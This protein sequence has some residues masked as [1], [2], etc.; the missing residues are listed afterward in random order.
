MTPRKQA[1]HEVQQRA[2]QILDAAAQ[3]FASKGFHKATTRDIAA[4]AQ[5]AEGTLYNYYGSKREMLFALMQRLGNMS[6]LETVQEESD[7]DAKTYYIED[8][9][10]RLQ[11]FRTAP[12]LWKAVIPEI[13][14]DPEL[15]TLFL[16]S[17][18]QQYLRF[19]EPYL[20]R[21]VAQ[22]EIAP[23]DNVPLTAR[24]MQSIPLGILIMV[25]L[26]DPVIMAEWDSLPETM[27]S[28]VYDGLKHA[29]K[30]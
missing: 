14:V 13:L 9:R 29:K 10:V 30:D 26:G 17:L 23:I 5:V 11:G 3:V 2:D 18:Q 27:A 21:R 28:L 1:D 8:A 20:Q 12:E 6:P 7:H 19:V 16:N 22:G 24:V 25:L 15:R 4:A